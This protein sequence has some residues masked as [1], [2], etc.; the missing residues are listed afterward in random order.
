MPLNKKSYVL[1]ITSLC[2]ILVAPIHAQDGGALIKHIMYQEFDKAKELIKQG[3]DVNYQ[4]ETY[5][6][7]ALLLSCQ[8]G[9]VDMA[10]YLVEKGA[11]LNIQAKNGTS[12]LM[13]SAG[14]SL[15]L[16]KYL[17]SRGADPALKSKEGTTA[18]TQ[19]IMGI[20]ME[21]VTIEAAELFL[22]TGADVDEA[23][24]TG[25]TAGYTC[26]M[27]AARNKR[28][29]L[30]KFLVEKGANVNAKAA[31]GATPLSLAAKENDSDMIALLKKL[32]AK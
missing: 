16:S 2:I 17:L 6:S 4:D 14:V 19:S 30:V 31:D 18:F 23:A 13:A 7:T 21:R 20:L 10:K 12:P 15:E 26:L 1:S 5:G 8:Y 3:V 25:A 27:M 32:G 28:P 29:D 11:D 9:F 22:E 24:A